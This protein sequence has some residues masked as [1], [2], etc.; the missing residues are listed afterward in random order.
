MRRREVQAVGSVLEELFK[1]RPSV[2]EKLYEA[3]ITRIWKEILGAG[4]ASFTRRIWLRK[5]ELFIQLNSSVLRNELTVNSPK[6]INE[7][8]KR[9]NKE[10]VKKIIFR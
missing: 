10:V 1:N 7:I 5:D 9:L 8:N 3:R 6:L 2:M 4:A